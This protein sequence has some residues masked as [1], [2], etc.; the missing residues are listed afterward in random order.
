MIFDKIADEPGMLERV[1]GLSRI[2]QLALVATSISER[3]IAAVPD[4]MRR[5]R[6]QSVPVEYVGTAGFVL[7]YSRLDVD[8]LGPSEPIEAIAKGRHK[9]IAD[10]L[11]AATARWEALPLVTEDTGLRKA[12]ARELPAVDLWRW[13][14]LHVRIASL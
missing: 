9:E 5:E 10:A 13:S 4:R 11:V 12:V 8:R 1:Q 6:L 7:D 3:Q 14:D 2:D